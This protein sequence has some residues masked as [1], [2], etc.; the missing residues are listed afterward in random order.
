MTSLAAL[1]HAMASMTDKKSLTRPD[2][3]NYRISVPHKAPVLWDSV[4]AVHSGLETAVTFPRLP[5][6]VVILSV[7]LGHRS[8]QSKGMNF[9]YLLLKGTLLFVIFTI[10]ITRKRISSEL[11]QHL[12]LRK[13]KLGFAGTG[14][15][16][17]PLAKE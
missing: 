2:H 15:H 5:C 1:L 3:Q 11:L 4:R 9:V 16:L 6:E 8:L 14:I 12:I 17:S 7:T 10:H 13:L